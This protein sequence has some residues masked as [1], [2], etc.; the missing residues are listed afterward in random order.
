M[1]RRLAG[2]ARAAW[3]LRQ[4]QIVAW[5]YKAI[6]RVANVSKR[7]HAHLLQFG[8]RPREK[9]LCQGESEPT[10]VPVSQIYAAERCASVAAERCRHGP[11]SE[12]H[13]ETS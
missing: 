6:M 11:T 7:Y 2:S 4:R 5:E 12:S 10:S 3:S 13:L 8:R 1:S 9:L